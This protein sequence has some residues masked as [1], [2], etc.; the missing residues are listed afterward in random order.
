CHGSKYTIIGEKRD[1]PAPRGMD[2]F[3]HRIENGVYIVDTSVR[4][5]GPPIGTDTFDSRRTEDI[6]HCAS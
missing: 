1:G 3:E 6:P 4:I 2:H 5:S